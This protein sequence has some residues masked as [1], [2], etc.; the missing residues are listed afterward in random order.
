MRI[1]KKVLSLILSFSMLLGLCAVSAGATTTGQ[2]EL[3]AED[4]YVTATATPDSDHTYYEVQGLN[5][6]DEIVSDSASAADNVAKIDDKEYATLAEAVANAT[7]GDTITLLDS[8]SGSGVKVAENS[9]FIVDLNGNT[10]TVTNPTVGSAGTETNGFQLLKGSKVTFRNGTIKAGT[11]KILIQ[12]YCNLTLEDVTLDCSEGAENL[13]VLSNNFGC[14]TMKGNTNIIAREGQQAFDLWYGLSS[15]GLYDDGVSVTFDDTF[16]GSVSGVIEYGCQRA[17]EGWQ[18]K[19]ILNINGSG[20]FTGPIVASSTNALDGAGINIKSGTFGTLDALH[21]LAEDADITI[22]LAADAT[23]DVVIP[24]NATVTLD[25]NGK[26]LTNVSADTITNHGTLTITG[27][28]TVD[29]VTDSKAALKNEADAVAI[30][31][32]GSFT[33]SKEAGYKNADGTSSHGG[34]SYYTMVNQGAMTINAGVVIENDGTYSSMVENGWPTASANTN[35]LPATMIING[36]TFNGGLYNLKNDDYGILTVLGGTFDGGG[37]GSLLNWNT[38]TLSNGTFGAG[39]A[40]DMVAYNCYDSELPSEQH[41]AYENGKLI[42]SGGDFTGSLNNDD[43]ASIAISSGYFTVDP[44]TYIVEGKVAGTSD[45]ANYA[46]MIKEAAVTGVVVKPADPTVNEIPSD[47]PTM[48]E[49]EKDTLTTAAQ[50]VS[51]DDSDTGLKSTAGDVAGS[52]TETQKQTATEELEAAGVDTSEATVTV[53]IQPKLEVTPEAYDSTK[54]ELTLD[55]KA[56]YDTVAT[57]DPGN[58]ITDGEDKNAT[59]VG[60]TK[61]LAIEDGTPVVIK[62]QIPGEMASAVTPATDPATYES[63][64]IKH[65]KETGSVYY[66]TAVVTETGGSYYATFTV[67]H[68]FSTITVMTADAREVTVNYSTTGSTVDPSKTYSI[69]DVGTALPT[70]TKSGYSFKGWKFTGLSDTYTTLPDF[71]SGTTDAIADKTATAQFSYNGGGSG[72][73]GVSSY[74]LT[75]D[76]NGGSALSSVSKT[77]GTTVDLTSY[78]PTKTGYTFDGWCS[79]KLLTKSVTSVKL[80]ANTTVY[81]KWTEVLANPF[82]DVSDDAYYYD[83]VLWAVDQDVTSGTSAT[84]FNPD[85]ICTRAQAVTFLWRADGQPEPTSAACPFTDVSASA[86]YY[87]AVLWAVEKGIT[88]GTTDTT[89]SP[90]ATCSRGQIVTFLYRAA[91][92]PSVGTAGGFTDVAGDAYY[93]DAVAWAVSENITNGTTDTTFSPD[94]DCTRAQIVTF[95][96]RDSI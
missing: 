29:N 65:V 14:V 7:A 32:G 80:T 71:W 45:K 69:T 46:F 20:T 41:T 59:K 50:G 36:G 2:L 26:K 47:A 25:L 34:N 52:V 55:I 96:W 86:Y 76:V 79:D 43:G 28:G 5:Q 75:F 9:D 23:A 72:G 51:V 8:V 16:T 56:K 30:L 4:G 31:D 60:E 78:K 85:G 57:T 92:S 44:T 74:T 19:T 3:S 18:S 68:G 87:K 6:S 17:L 58:I 21:Y 33:R 42:I 22:A 66:Y 90:D 35:K 38:A 89:F 70:S 82:V 53:V 1:S 62:V 54:K 27:N 67:T 11:S 40:N 39:S 94:A 12:N 24:A 48:T 64:T 93:A 84:T 37:F 83:A 61:T 95:L 10:Y 88:N 91:G 15:Q 73:G 49:D 13:Y 77:S 81:A 63:L